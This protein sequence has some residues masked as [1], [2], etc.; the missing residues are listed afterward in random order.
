SGPR[1][2]SAMG[3]ADMGR[4]DDRLFYLHGSVRGN[5]SGGTNRAERLGGKT[6]MVRISVAALLVCAGLSAAPD[7]AT[8]TFSKDVARILHQR[9]VECHRAGEAAPMSLITYQ[10]ARPW[11]KAIKEAV[12]QRVM[13][14]W[15]AD[16]HY[17]SFTNDRR[18]P[19]RDVQ[20]LVAW[21]D[22]GAPEGDPKL[23][24]PVPHFET[25]WS[26]G[27]PDVVIDMGTDFDVP[28]DGTVVY[29]YFTVPKNFTED[30]WV[31]SAEVRPDKRAV[32]HHV[33]A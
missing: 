13:P 29:K 26:I 12:L 27:K 32:V 10:E 15:L 16:P 14:P 2:R 6:M 18:M 22:G 20:T 7:A 28:G 8:P 25:G 31:E 30:K 3:R 11:A 5:H 33:I 24:P 4:D 23:T 9:C 1:Q 17:G 21:A 19:D